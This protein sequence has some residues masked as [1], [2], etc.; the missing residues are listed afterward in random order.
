MSIQ[1]NQTRRKYVEKTHSARWIVPVSITVLLIALSVSSFFLG[2]IAALEQ[3]KQGV[4][5][6]TIPTAI[7]PLQTKSSQ[8]EVGERGATF[9]ESAGDVMLVG[10]V[11]SN[12]YHFPW[13]S[14]ARRINEENKLT[15]TSYQEAQQAGYRPAKNCEGLE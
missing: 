3:R 2:K 7:A 13:C 6:E 15:F 10:S 12:V 14:G 8:E 9:S 4:V 11:N 5:V 1:K